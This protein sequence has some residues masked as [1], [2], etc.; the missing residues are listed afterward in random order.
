LRSDAKGLLLTAHANDDEA[1]RGRW[2]SVVALS[3]DQLVAWGALYYAYGVLSVPIAEGLGVSAELVAGAFSFAL[4][5]SGVA[6]LPLG[7]ALDRDGARVVLLAGSIAG[8]AALATIAVAEHPAALFVAFGVLGFG[9]AAALYEPA[10]RAI[11]DW[12]PRPA[13]RTRALLVLTSV[14]GF[15]STLFLPVTAWLLRDWGWRVALLV[16]AG[17][18][19]AVGATVALS[20]SPSRRRFTPRK[21]RRFLAPARGR[22]DLVAVA[23]ALQSL[24]STGVSVALVWFLVAGGR[25]LEGAAALAGLAGAAQVPGRL[26][27]AVLQRVVSSGVRVPLLF[28]LQACAIAA[29]GA[30]SEEGRTVAVIV[31]GLAGGTMTI[32]RATILSEWF[33]G[34][35]FGTRSARVAFIGALA[36]ASSPYAVELLRGA[37]GFPATFGLLAGLVV[38]GGVL[39]ALA[40]QAGIDRGPQALG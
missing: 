7:R 35:G 20:I 11:V 23:F 39:L 4:L 13:E 38:A 15:A 31:F 10:I 8:S 30:D 32:E 3:V 29:L 28:V 1:R 9:H 14:G 6:A 12:F 25:D 17:S 40:R 19:A 5:V 18:V 21:E 26:G 16:L 27:L 33:R 22:A 24:A 36:R 34:E 37:F 2:A